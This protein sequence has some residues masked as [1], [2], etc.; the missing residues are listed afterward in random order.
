MAGLVWAMLKLLLVGRI[1]LVVLLLEEETSVEDEE[2]TKNISDGRSR[3]R[4]RTAQLNSAKL[5][6]RNL[7]VRS[8]RVSGRNSSLGHRGSEQRVYTIFGRFGD[9]LDGMDGLFGTEV[10][11]A[12]WR[13]SRQQ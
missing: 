5:A 9:G 1:V 8:E 13:S 2:T 12:A 11:R 6:S 7:S 4:R 3:S 10:D